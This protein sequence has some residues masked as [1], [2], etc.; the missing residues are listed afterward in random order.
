M[1]ATHQYGRKADLALGLWVKLA[2]ASA[3]FAKLSQTD[4]SR[5]GLTGPQF[6]VVEALG[7]LGPMPIGELGRKMLAS[8]G[9]MTVVVDNLQRAGLVDRSHDRDDRRAIVVDL[10]PKGR[11]LFRDIFP[12]H[13]QFIASMSSVLTEREQTEL[14]RLLKKLGLACRKHLLRSIQT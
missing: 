5:Y 6:S 4:I 11:K 10:T 8:G 14:A 2:R 9:N 3:T 12:R 1:K 13:A 7:H